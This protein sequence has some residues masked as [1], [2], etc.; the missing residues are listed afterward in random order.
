MFVCWFAGF[1]VLLF[2]IFLD[3]DNGGIVLL[4]SYNLRISIVA[5]ESNLSGR[6]FQCNVTFSAWYQKCY[7]HRCTSI[8]CWW[9]AT[10]FRHQT[11]RGSNE[12]RDK[13]SSRMFHSTMT[14]WTVTGNA[15]ASGH[16]A[17]R[18]S[19]GRAAHYIASRYLIANTETGGNKNNWTESR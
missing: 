12:C 8:C 18:I 13:D 2:Y 5:N 7:H 16:W 15:W 10:D 9:R 11:T 3:D 14:T 6:E 1:V 19:S 17:I 4:S